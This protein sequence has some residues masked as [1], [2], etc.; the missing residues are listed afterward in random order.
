MSLSGCRCDG[1]GCQGALPALAERAGRLGLGRADRAQ[2]R[3]LRRP[4]A[5]RK[6]QG[7]PSPGLLTPSNPREACVAAQGP[8][9]QFR[10]RVLSPAPSTGRGKALSAAVY[11]PERMRLNS[12]K[13]LSCHW[14]VRHR[15][16]SARGT[17]RRLVVCALDGGERDRP[18]SLPAQH[19]P[20]LAD[21]EGFAA[22]MVVIADGCAQRAPASAGGT[23]HSPPPPA[24]AALA[25][26][27]SAG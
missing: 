5:A 23:A 16:A 27:I 24:R 25:E 9:V 11:R 19:M 17:G 12:T 6:G 13:I 1:R 10:Y 2:H 4:A 7:K 8:S 14:H 3:R 18:G 20:A 22:V 26:A 21:H 15:E